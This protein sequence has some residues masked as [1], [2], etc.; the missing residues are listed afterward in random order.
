MIFDW[1]SSICAGFRRSRVLSLYGLAG[2]PLPQW[3]NAA[4]VVL[5]IGGVVLLFI[6]LPLFWTRALYGFLLVVFILMIVATIPLYSG[7]AGG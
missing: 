7:P 6:E 2:V 4:G 3:F 1:A 5:S